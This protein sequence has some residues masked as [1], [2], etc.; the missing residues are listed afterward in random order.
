MS[1]DYTAQA[2]LKQ[3][4]DLLRKVVQNMDIDTASD[5]EAFRKEYGSYKPLKIS[6]NIPCSP[7]TPD[8]QDWKPANE[9]NLPSRSEGYAAAHDNVRRTKDEILHEMT[10]LIIGHLN[11]LP[12]EERQAR[13][14]AFCNEL[15]RSTT[16]TAAPKEITAEML[17]DFTVWCYDDGDINYAEVA[18]RINEFFHA[19]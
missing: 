11:T 13:L 10:D 3:I 2:I 16:P 14:D 4:R 7:E 18:A 6:D 8:T 15:S 1:F 9:P 5:L 17:R 19:R 12:P